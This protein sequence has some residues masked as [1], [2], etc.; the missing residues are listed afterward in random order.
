MRSGRYSEPGFPH[1]GWEEQGVTDNG[2][3]DFLCEACERQ[4]IR[5]V[6]H[7]RHPSLNEEIC[8]GCVCAGYLTGDDAAARQ[9]EAAAQAAARKRTAWAKRWTQQQDGSWIHRDGYTVTFDIRSG[10]R[11]HGTL[12]ASYGS[13][14]HAKR[15]VMR[16]NFS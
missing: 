11:A 7:L 3:C 5:W 8:V 2:D 14:E 1:T 6:H 13:A 9:R 15:A 10:W 16:F 4:H 12:T